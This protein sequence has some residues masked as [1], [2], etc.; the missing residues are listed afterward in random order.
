MA[1]TLQELQDDLARVN[2]AIQNLIAGERVASF[3]IGSG[4]SVREYR[5]SE[6]TLDMLQSERNRILAEISVLSADAPT[7]RKSSRMQTAYS[8][9]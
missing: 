8:K 5:F 9:L 6:V 2:T 4:T 1:Q 7:F 3:R